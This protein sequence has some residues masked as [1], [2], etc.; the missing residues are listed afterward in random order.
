MNLML[1]TAAMLTL[2]AMATTFAFWFAVSSVP[3]GLP[4]ARGV[5]P[6]WMG[7]LLKKGLTGRSVQTELTHMRLFIGQTLPQ[8]LQ[9]SDS[10]DRSV[11]QPL[12]GL[13]SQ[14]PHP[15]KHESSMHML[16]MQAVLALGRMQFGQVHDPLT[17][18]RPWSQA[19]PHAPQFRAS[20]ER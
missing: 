4:D 19:W 2:M 5:F 8:A 15:G 3:Q 18:T 10:F 14:L 13:L 6:V 16:L 1:V 11:S 9:L 12:A 7:M 20:E 17:H